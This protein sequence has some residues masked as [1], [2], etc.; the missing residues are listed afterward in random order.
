MRPHLLW[1][2]VAL[3][4]LLSACGK[5]DSTPQKANESATQ[6]AGTMTA[7]Q[8][9]SSPT[10][11][12]SSIFPGDAPTT[13][14]TAAIDRLLTTVQ[15]PSG[16]GVLV[17]RDITNDGTAAEVPE[18]GKRFKDT[19]R[20]IGVFYI[21]G[22]GST[23]R[24]TLSINQ[25]RQ[26]DGARQEFDFGKGNPSPADQID[27]AGIGEEAAASRVRLQSGEASASPLVLS[28]TRGR[29]YVVLSEPTATPESTPD[30]LLQ[31][32]RAID[33]RLKENPLP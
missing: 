20:E 4:V 8:P 14:V 18:V 22:A 5:S 13:T 26:A 33:E 12:M 6:A 27:A 29:Y 28:F 10:P 11:D 2:G 9:A 30:T 25:Y 15:L 31:L 24:M 32:A 1:S 19:G 17:R 21:M 23:P 3:L 7:A 16:V